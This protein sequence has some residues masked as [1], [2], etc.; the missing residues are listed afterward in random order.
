M[1]KWPGKLADEKDRANVVPAQIRV[2]LW[3]GLEKYEKDW[4][5]SHIDEKSNGVIS[6]YAET[7]CL[8]LLIF[9]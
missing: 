9:K 7:V 4:V 6:I 1:I 3:L 8:F 2:K 5:Q